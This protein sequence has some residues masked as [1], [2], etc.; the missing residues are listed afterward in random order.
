MLAGTR[1]TGS[2]VPSLCLGGGIKRGMATKNVVVVVAVVMV[3][4]MHLIPLALSQRNCNLCVCQKSCL[5]CKLCTL[6]ETVT[7]LR[8]LARNTGTTSLS[9]FS[10]CAAQCDRACIC[11][12]S[13]SHVNIVRWLART[14]GCTRRSALLTFPIRSNHDCVEACT[15]PHVCYTALFFVHGI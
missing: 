4:I 11:N 3:V 12:Q 15:H 6:A 10:P 2:F 8:G 7:C 14:V 13:Y 5:S 1:W 9:P